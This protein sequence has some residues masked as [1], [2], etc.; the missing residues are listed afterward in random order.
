M[1]N[2]CFQQ[3]MV[4]HTSIFRDHI[5]NFVPQESQGG[6]F[7]FLPLFRLMNLGTKFHQTTSLLDM[8]TK[9]GHNCIHIFIPRR[10]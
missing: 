3:I 2:D 10:I 9:S 4:G 8:L 1:K 7:E 5:S 6:K